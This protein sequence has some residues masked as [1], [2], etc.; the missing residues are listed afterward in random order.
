MEARTTLGS[1]NV[2]CSV[3]CFSVGGGRIF[4]HCRREIQFFYSG[5]HYKPNF[6]SGPWDAPAKTDSPTW[7]CQ[8]RERVRLSPS[9]ECGR[10]QGR[11]QAGLGV[12]LRSQTGAKRGFTGTE[13][14]ASNRAVVLNAQAARW[15]AI[16]P[17]PPLYYF[18]SQS[19]CGHKDSHLSIYL[20][21]ALGNFP[22]IWM[23]SVLGPASSLLPF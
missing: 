5:T 21:P 22:R 3:T 13:K 20:P 11:L 10:G 17:S 7:T 23:L 9:V 15:P 12:R 14:W 2:T 4:T 18:V 16:F 8:S 1:K 19:V 6:T